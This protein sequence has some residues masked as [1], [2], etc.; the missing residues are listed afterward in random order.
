MKGTANPGLNLHTFIASCQKLAKDSFRGSPN[1]LEAMVSQCE[2][3][4]HLE[5][6]DPNAALREREREMR[7]RRR[8][9]GGDDW[10]KQRR[11]SDGGGEGRYGLVGYLPPLGF[12]SPESGSPLKKGSAPPAGKDGGIDEMTEDDQTPG[13]T[14][15]SSFL[16]DKVQDRPFQPHR[17]GYKNIYHMLQDVGK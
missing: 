4:L 11:N 10:Q 9:K 14:W 8:K 2:L 5:Q 13:R 6:S 1:P 17:G 7:R 12:T 3:Y 16:T 15:P